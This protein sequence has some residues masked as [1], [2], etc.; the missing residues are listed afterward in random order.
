M[1]GEQI[2]EEVAGSHHSL[3]SMDDKRKESM[4]QESEDGYSSGYRV[5]GNGG[6]CNNFSATS[7]C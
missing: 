4:V 6:V 3:G 7:R 5:C 1:A 2:G